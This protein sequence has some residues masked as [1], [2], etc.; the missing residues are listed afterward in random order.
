MGRFDLLY[1]TNPP[2]PLPG[3]SLD[4]NIMKK[5]AA[6]DYLVS[7][8]Y[9]SYSY[10]IKFLREAALD[11]AVTSIK[12]TLYRL[13]KNSQIISSLINAAKN[14]KKVTVQIELQA[15]FDEASNIFYSEQMQMEGIELIF[16]VKGL[17]VHSK[18]CV[19]ERQEGNKIHRYGIISTGNFNESTAKVYTDVTLF[20]AHQKILKDVSKVFEFFEINY[21]IYNYQHIITSPHFTRNKFNKLINREIAHAK[22]G[23]TTYMLSLIH[24]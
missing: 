21:R 5:I 12:I 2:L 18:I 10:V 24:I 8:P 20:T 16:G 9:Q 7:A 11:P 14:G 4:E 19:I 17:K 23:R 6:K 1:K 22:E 13:A 3:L 15:R